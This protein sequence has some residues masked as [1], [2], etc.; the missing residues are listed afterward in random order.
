MASLR[1]EIII[2][3]SAADVFAVVGRPELI[4]LWFPGVVDCT[5]DGKVRIVT[6]GAG[7]PMPEEIVTNDSLQHRLQYRIDAP[8]FRHHL[9]TF[10]AIDIDDGRCM[11]V[12]STDA[13]PDVMALVVGGA[14]NGALEE[15]K[16]QF[17][18]GRGPALDAVRDT[19]PVKAGSN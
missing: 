9:A 16:R 4:H 18:S 6:T 15:L 12:Y 14:T 7:I 3:A 2:N 19:P 8:L 1:R 5:F 17:D 10:D 11:C 13:E